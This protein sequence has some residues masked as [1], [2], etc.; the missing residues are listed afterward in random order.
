MHDYL[1]LVMFTAMF[2]QTAQLKDKLEKNVLH[3]PTALKLATILLNPPPVISNVYLMG[4]SVLM[5]RLWMKTG[6]NV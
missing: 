5:E 6:M 2:L 3:I 4:V 1:L